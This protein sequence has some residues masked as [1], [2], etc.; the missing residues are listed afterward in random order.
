[1]RSRLTLKLGR[2]KDSGCFKV[3]DAITGAELKVVVLMLKLFP[4]RALLVP[5]KAPIGHGHRVTDLGL[6]SC[7]SNSVTRL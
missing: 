5:L 1:M 7:S 6:F 4:S 2:K 3:G